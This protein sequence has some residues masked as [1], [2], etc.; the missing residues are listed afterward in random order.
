MEI[1]LRLEELSETE[2]SFI[3]QIGVERVDVHNPVLVPGYEEQGDEYFQNIPKVLK[4][5]RKSGIDIASFRY[6]KIRN[7]LMGKPEGEKEVKNHCRVIEVLGEND[8]HL[9]QVD[10]HSVR[11]SPGGVPGR[12]KTKQRGGYIMDAFSLSR[13]RKNLSTQKG[14][15][16]YVHHFIDELS[17]EEYFG[18]CVKVYE[19][20]IPVLEDSGVKLAIHTD[21]PPI[22]D[23]EGLLPGITTPEKIQ[24]LFDTVPSSNSG[25]LFCT[26]TRYESGIDIFEQI[27]KLGPKI[28]H[29]H[30]RNVKGTIPKTGGYEEVTMDDGDMDMLKVLRALMDVG[31]KGALNPDHFP[32]LAGD[33]LNRNAGRA[34]SVGY[35]RALLSSL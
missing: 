17:S 18:N 4:R 11:L 33:T 21:D 6:P 19:K 13:M 30:F 2:L 31:Y 14:D 7:A 20:I 16:K 35:I 12:Y 5:I 28:F 25:L 8:A 27:E 9:I 29:V 3:R 10:F 26:G 23:K 32:I 24:K 22:P 34:F 1:S 15:S